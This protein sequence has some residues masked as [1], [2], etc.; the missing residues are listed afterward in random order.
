LTFVLKK[1]ISKLD[2]PNSENTQKTSYDRP[3][4]DIKRI[5]NTKIDPRTGNGQGY[6]IEEGH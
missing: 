5:M 4:E 1:W 6:C 3:E 2:K